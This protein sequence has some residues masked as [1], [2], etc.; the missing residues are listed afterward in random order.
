MVKLTKR[1]QKMMKLGANEL[2]IILLIVILLFGVGRLSRIGSELGQ[3]VGNFR[4]HTQQPSD[5]KAK[6]EE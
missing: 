1:V 4:K 5:D 2:L 6:N 3:A